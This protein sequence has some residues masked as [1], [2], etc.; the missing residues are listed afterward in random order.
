LPADFCNNIYCEYKFYM[1]DN[2]YTTELCP[3]KNQAP[4]FSYSKLH[5]IDCVTKF[6]IDYLREDKLTV[7]IYGN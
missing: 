2:K 5:H 6:L 1:D 4:E 3:G 7:K